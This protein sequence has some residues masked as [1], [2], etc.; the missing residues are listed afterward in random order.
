MLRLQFVNEME[1]M[2]REMNQF[3]R[4]FGLGEVNSPQGERVGFRVSEK[5][6]RFVVEAAIPG[7]DPEELNIDVLGR[8]L[9]VSG[10]FRESDAGEDVR[11]YRKERRSGSFEQNIQ[12]TAELDTDKVVA[13]YEHGIL[14]IDLPKAASARPKKITVNAA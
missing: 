14:R 11:W 2:H 4:N 3:F 5:D 1:N 13:E 12:L 7:I 8:K 6:D 9:T 10:K